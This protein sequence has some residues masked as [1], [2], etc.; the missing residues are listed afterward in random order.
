MG[1][2]RCLGRPHWQWS[3]RPRASCMVGGRGRNPPGSS[4]RWPLGATQTRVTRQR[5][6]QLE[7]R[8]GQSHTM[9][10]FITVTECLHPYYS[11][12]R[13]V[14]KGG[15]TNSQPGTVS[16]FPFILKPSN[17]LCKGCI[18]LMLKRHMHTIPRRFWSKTSGF[19][20]LAGAPQGRRGF[21]SELRFFHLHQASS[22]NPEAAGP[23]RGQTSRLPPRQAPP[24]GAGQTFP[25]SSHSCQQGSPEHTCLG[26]LQTHP[27]PAR[28]PPSHRPLSE[29]AQ[30]GTQVPGGT[31]EAGSS[32]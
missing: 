17:S 4:P 9:R 23:R 26:G 7:W 3:G 8:L 1:S 18:S 32:H 14:G 29:A 22:L 11:L 13:A 21:S 24:V 28:S 25:P 16:P 20:P 12:S 15:S 6:I 2:S 31:V 19:L 30:A 10:W 27:R 5:P